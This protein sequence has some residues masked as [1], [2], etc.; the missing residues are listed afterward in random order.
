MYV[1]THFAASEAEVARLL[2]ELTAVDLITA[3]PDGLHATFLPMLHDASAGSLVGH[4]A[5]NNPHWRAV[6]EAAGESL[7]IVR[8]PD[9]YIS[10][11]WYASKAE[12]G[13]V[14]P[15]WN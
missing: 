15:T 7:A 13:R 9:A 12:H 3:G 10:P 2:V 4:V 6:G 11:S 5:R 8:G 14:V 1:P